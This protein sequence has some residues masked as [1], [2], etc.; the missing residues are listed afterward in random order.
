MDWSFDPQVVHGRT[1]SGDSGRPSR[2]PRRSAP[3][4]RRPTPAKLQSAASRCW[5]ASAS[6]RSCFQLSSFFTNFVFRR[7]SISL[8]LGRATILRVFGHSSS[9]STRSSSTWLARP[10]RQPKDGTWIRPAPGNA[11]TLARCDVCAYAQSDQIDHQSRLTIT[12][13]DRLLPVPRTAV[14]PSLRGQGAR[15]GKS[16]QTT[17]AKKLCWCAPLPLSNTFLGCAPC[18][19][20]QALST[21]RQAGLDI[22]DMRASVARTMRN[23]CRHSFQTRQPRDKSPAVACAARE[24]SWQQVGWSSKSGRTV[25]AEA[26]NRPGRR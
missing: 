24:H 9:I 17:A 10:R 3:R 18:N 11:T 13:F 4:P 6:L 12:V 8:A 14:T 5:T 15:E 21:E 16:T 19:E 7:L 23:R 22:G 1:T 2:S 25:A 26:R 20:N